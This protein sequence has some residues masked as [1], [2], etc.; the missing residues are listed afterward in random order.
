MAGLPGFRDSSRRRVT[1]APFE[2]LAGPSPELI[3]PCTV[4][5]EGTLLL[6]GRLNIKEKREAE[7][8]AA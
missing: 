4:S 5:M 1:D 2:R 6:E 7:H 8:I 3:W